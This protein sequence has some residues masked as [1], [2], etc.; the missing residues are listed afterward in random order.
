MSN[1]IE[2]GPAGGECVYHGGKPDSKQAALLN[3]IEDDCAQRGNC[4]WLNVNT[5]RGRGG[6][7]E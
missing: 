2:G 3:V 6:G 4:M 7:K 5:S 1:H